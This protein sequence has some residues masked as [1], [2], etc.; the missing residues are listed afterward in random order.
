MAV[1]DANYLFT[2]VDIGT[3]GRR[4]DGGIFKECQFGKKFEQ[5]KMNVP[6]AEI[7]SENGPTLPYCLVGDEAFPLKDYLLRPYPE[8]GGL[9]KEKAVFNYRLSSA[10]Q[11]I[12][13]TFGILACQ[14][15]TLRKPIIAKVETVEKI[16]QA[17]VCVH[18]WLRKQDININ[19]YVTTSLIDHFDHN[20]FIPGTWRTVL[21]N[22]SA[23]RKIQRTGSYMN[24]RTSIEIREQFCT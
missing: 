21:E 17:I 15:R 22:S 1:C 19:E 3:Y 14:W 4:S 11:M 16:V 2:L 7:V 20:G 23:Y 12:E 5:K 6:D 9:T 18:N 24:V 10:R 8:R 13:N